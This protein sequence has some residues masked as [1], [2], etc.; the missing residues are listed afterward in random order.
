[1]E[2]EDALLRLAG[3]AAVDFGGSVVADAPR[4]SVVVP[5][6]SSQLSATQLGTRGPRPQWSRPRLR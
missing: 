6:A 4:E 3:L 2:S 5:Q 1:M